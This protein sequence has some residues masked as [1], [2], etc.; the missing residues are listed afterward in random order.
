MLEF[1]EKNH[2][3]LQSL[4]FSLNAQHFTKKISLEIGQ[5]LLY[6]NN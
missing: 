5:N 2:K 1:L 4:I 3:T 6:Q